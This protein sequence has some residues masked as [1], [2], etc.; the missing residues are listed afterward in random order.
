[1]NRKPDISLIGTKLGH[2]NDNSRPLIFLGSSHVM[3]KLVEVCDAFSITVAGIIDRDYYGNTVD[4][5]GIPVIDSED[6]FNNYASLENYK[7]NYNF[8]CATNWTR[9]D[10]PISLRNKQKRLDHIKLVRT[11]GLNC[12]SLVDH[13]ARISK[14]SQIGRGVFL[15]SHVLIEPRS[16]IGD[17]T[18]I[19]YNSMIGHHCTVGENCVFQRQCMLMGYNLV[20][21]NSYFSPAVKALKSGAEFGA[22]T[23]IQEAIYIK[24]GTMED[25]T[26]SLHS[27]NQ[28]RV[29]SSS[30]LV[31]E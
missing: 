27:G 25:E 19:F 26:V 1:M 29:T 6:N 30:T 22:N 18:S 4:L 21:E 31:I 14:Y 28:R 24:R 3:E 12:I 23:Y 7:N 17:F 9:M 8:F 20:G 15:D 13:T 5:C 10:D 11:L 16:T 2:I